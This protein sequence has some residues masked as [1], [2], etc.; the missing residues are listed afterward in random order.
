MLL[1]NLSLKFKLREYRRQVKNYRKKELEFG[2]KKR[3]SILIRNSWTR[4]VTIS[5]LKDPYSKLN[6]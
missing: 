5:I 3:S 2:K 6:Y 1:K 4:L